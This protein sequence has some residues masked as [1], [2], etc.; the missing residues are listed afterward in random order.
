[1]S[2][3]KIIGT[4]S[5]VETLNTKTGVE[6]KKFTL[7][8]LIFNKDTGEVIIENDFPIIDFNNLTDYKHIENKRF[9]VDCSVSTYT[10]KTETT[11]FQNV[12][13]NAKKIN[14]V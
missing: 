11:E 4:I 2:Y 1:M 14:I 6:F 3:T 13:L 12:R 5:K 7:K 10:V 9:E 8:E